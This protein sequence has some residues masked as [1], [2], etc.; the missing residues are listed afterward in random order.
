MWQSFLLLEVQC[1]EKGVYLSLARRKIFKK[2][3]RKLDDLKILFSMYVA[4][5]FNTFMIL[6]KKSTKKK[7]NQNILLSYLL[8]YNNISSK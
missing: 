6:L 4:V 1:T 3:P 8:I 5:Y 2:V 7:S